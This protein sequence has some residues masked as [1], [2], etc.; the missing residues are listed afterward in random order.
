MTA[1]VT[2]RLTDSEYRRLLEALDCLPT[3]AEARRYLKLRNKLV[4]VG[5][6]EADGKPKSDQPFP[7]DPVAQCGT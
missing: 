2:L 6:L 3:P 5:E 1:M 4:G 7:G